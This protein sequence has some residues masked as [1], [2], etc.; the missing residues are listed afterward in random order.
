MKK[1]KRIKPVVDLAHHHERDAAKILGQALTEVNR[2]EQQLVQLKQY[3]DEYAERFNAAGQVGESISKL[4]DFLAFLTKIK[5]AVKAQEQAVEAA[6]SVLEE[7]K[8]FWF[9]KRGRSKALD[10]VLDKYVK[11]EREL[12]AKKEQKEQ[13]DLRKPVSNH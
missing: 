3:Q 13:D 10:G 6:R 4:N 11:E 2:H 8:Q 5:G 7:K 12:V 9:S 1:S